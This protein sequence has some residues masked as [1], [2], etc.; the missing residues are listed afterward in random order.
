MRRLQ[1]L[2][3]QVLDRGP[4]G[5]S[6]SAKVFR[7]VMAVTESHRPDPEDFP[8]LRDGDGEPTIL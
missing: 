7:C 3:L 5:Y 6:E 2:C 1:A 4:T 8:D